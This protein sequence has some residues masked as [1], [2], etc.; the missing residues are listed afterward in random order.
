MKIN[1]EERNNNAINGN[2]N[3]PTI[4]KYNTKNIPKVI[5]KKSLKLNNHADNI[6]CNKS[7]NDKVKSKIN[8]ESIVCNGNGVASKKIINSGIINIK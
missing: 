4:K 1:V 2:R 3:L 5:F 6:A 8:I 7:R